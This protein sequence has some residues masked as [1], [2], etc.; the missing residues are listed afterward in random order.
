MVGKTEGKPE[1]WDKARKKDLT[2]KSYEGDKDQ[3]LI[4]E[5]EGDKCRQSRDRMRLSKSS[6]SESERL[7]RKL[8]FQEKG[9]VDP[10]IEEIGMFLAMTTLS[11][12]G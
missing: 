2:V 10:R 11:S 5:T 1:I 7:R 6:I 12:L 8:K 4:S 9:R 3:D